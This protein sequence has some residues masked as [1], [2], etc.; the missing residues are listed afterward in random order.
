MN[1]PPGTPHWLSLAISL[2]TLP[3]LTLPAV[4]QSTSPSP[5]NPGDRPAAS[6]PAPEIGWEFEGQ[7]ALNRVVLDEITYQG[8][9]P[10]QEGSQVEA[11]FFSSKT[12]PAED[13]R[14][15]IRTV[16]RG[17]VGDPLPYTDREYNK[18]RASEATKIRFG[19]RHDGKYMQV[20]PGENQFEYEIKERGNGI[21]SGRFTAWINKN[22]RVV[23]RDAVAKDSQVCANSSV[24]LNVCADLR[25]QTEYKCPDGRV[26]RRFLEPDDTRVSTVIAN[27]TFSP[28]Y[29][30]VN[31]TVRSLMPGQATT[32]R[33]PNSSTYLNLRFNPTCTTCP[34]N[35]SSSLQPG[36]RYQFR[37]SSGGGKPVEL[38]DY[39]NR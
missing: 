29:F 18:G 19:S 31:G 24:A 39:P 28:V 10:G 21:D 33:S 5:A 13:R 17:V 12:P 20:L 8:E 23:Q 7:S 30:T 11:R 34:P 9:C 35:N 16:T 2:A 22:Q 6:Q 38:V 14:V 26:L 37:P 1:T 25:N 15:V 4:P 36:K 32:Y 3:A 27:Q